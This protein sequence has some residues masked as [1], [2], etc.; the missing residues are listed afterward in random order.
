MT[1]RAAWPRLPHLIAREERHFQ[2]DMWRA[3]Q[4]RYWAEQR[5]MMREGTRTI[6][7]EELHALLAQGKL[8][9]RLPCDP[10]PWSEW[11]FQGES[12]EFTVEVSPETPDEPYHTR[13]CDKRGVEVGIYE[14][15]TL[16]LDH[17]VAWDEFVKNY[18]PWSVDGMPDGLVLA[19]ADVSETGVVPPQPGGCAPSV[20]HDALRKLREGTCDLQSPVPVA[21]NTVPPTPSVA[22]GTP[23]GAGTLFRGPAAPPTTATTT[24]PWWAAPPPP[25][26]PPML[27]T[28]SPPATPPKTT[29]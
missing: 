14:D 8:L 20:V 13:I 19:P 12:R 22:I 17:F 15:T 11:I 24:L 1:K 26:T 23:T 28:P 18:E 9:A 25:A 29:P 21:Q 10:Q 3:G 5:M 2:D 7:Q 6:T 16:R 4:E 27:L